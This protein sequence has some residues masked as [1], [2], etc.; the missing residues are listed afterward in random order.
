MIEAVLKIMIPVMSIFSG[1]QTVR[2]AW[3]LVQQNDT[4]LILTAVGFGFMFFLTLLIV[5]GFLL[6]RIWQLTRYLTYV[7]RPTP[8]LIRLNP[9]LD[10]YEVLKENFDRDELEGAMFELN[11]PNE[12]DGLTHPGLI[13]K[14]M[15]YLDDRGQIDALRAWVNRERPGVLDTKE[16]G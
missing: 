11:V 14:V 2:S 5:I 16:I 10:L 15:A 4:W 6:Y 7:E 9:H 12:W 1:V 3:K 8:S 13:R